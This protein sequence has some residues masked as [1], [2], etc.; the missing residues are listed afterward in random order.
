M[1]GGMGIP[2]IG[3]YSYELFNFYDVDQ[4]IRIGS[5]GAIQDDLNVMDIVIGMGAC[6]DSDYVKQYNLP[7][8]YAPIADYGL[9]KRA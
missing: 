1:G 3:I 8:H 5:A 7:G 2:S 6:T 9:M 4:I